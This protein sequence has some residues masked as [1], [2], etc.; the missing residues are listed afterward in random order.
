MERVRHIA[1]AGTTI[2]LITHHIEEI[3]PEIARVI[4]LRGGRI[5][6]DGA[7]PSVLT[8]TSLTELFGVAVSVEE[9]HGYHHARAIGAG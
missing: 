7:K 9:T 2:I 4:L 1:R 3:I 8:G 5:V 6:R